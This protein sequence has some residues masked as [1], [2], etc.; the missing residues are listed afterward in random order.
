MAAGPSKLRCPKTD[1]RLYLT[2]DS[3]IFDPQG[4][5]FKVSSKV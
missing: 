3:V 1:F 5:L 2:H 4:E